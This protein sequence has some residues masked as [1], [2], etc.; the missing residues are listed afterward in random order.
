MSRYSEEEWRDLPERT[1]RVWENIGRDEL[2]R[3]VSEQ[4]VSANRMF[5]AIAGLVALV[6]VIAV[7][8]YSHAHAVIGASTGGLAMVTYATGGGGGTDPVSRLSTAGG[9]IYLVIVSVN[10]AHI[11][12]VNRH[13][14]REAARACCRRFVRDTDHGR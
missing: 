13:R 3:P 11:V 4:A 9:V 12:W 5:A 10:G 1:D 7:W 8:A 6:A 14:G 2:D